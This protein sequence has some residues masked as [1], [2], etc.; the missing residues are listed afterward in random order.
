MGLESYTERRQNREMRRQNMEGG[1]GVGAVVGVEVFL[2]LLLE[3]CVTLGE[4]RSVNRT[5]C[6]LFRVHWDCC[7]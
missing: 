3:R 7:A 4:D 2:L 6:E 5:W 1:E